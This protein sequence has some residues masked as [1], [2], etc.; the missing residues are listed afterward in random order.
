MRAAADNQLLTAALAYAAS[1][2]P[3]FPCSAADKTPLVKWRQAATTDEKQIRSWW[4]KHPDAM[5]GVPT[6]SPIGAFAID[7]DIGDV[8]SGPEFLAKFEQY[9][10]EIPPT[11]VVETG[12][13]GYHIYFA[14]DPDAPVHNGANIVPALHLNGTGGKGAQVDVRGEGGYVIVP[15]SV[16]TD[17]KRYSWCPGPEDGIAA[18]TERLKA[19]ALKKETRPDPEGDPPPLPPKPKID[20]DEATRRYALAALDDEARSIETAPNGSRNVTLN[21]AAF[22][23]GQLVGAG[24]LSE[25]V[26]RATLEDAATSCG[27]VREDGVKSVRDTIASGL[28]AGMTNP[29]DMARLLVGKGLK[30]KGGTRSAKK[31]DPETNWQNLLIRNRDGAPKCLLEN[32]MTVLKHHPE[33]RG[34]IGFDEFSLSTML[35]QPPPWDD[36]GEDL[37]RLP[38]QWTPQDDSL[39]TCWVQRQGLA[40]GFDVIQQAVETI[41]RQNGFHP[42]CNYLNGLKWDGTQRVETLFSHYLGAKATPFVAAVGRCFLVGA[43]ARAFHPG[44]KHDSLPILEG[45]QRIGKSTFASILGGSWFSDD[46]AELGSKDASLQMASAWIFELSELEAMGRAEATHIKAFISRSVDKFRPPYGRR[47]IEAPRQCVFIGTTNSDCYL[48]DETGGSRFWPVR[49]RKLNDADLRRDRDQLWAEA[50]QLY[51]EGAHW[52]LEDEDIIREAAEEQDARYEGDPWDDLISAYLAFRDVTSV[53]E[54][55]GDALHIEKGRWG[56]SEQMRVS[57]CLRHL[58]FD[59]QRSTV[60]GRRAWVYRRMVG[61]PEVVPKN[62]VFST[63]SVTP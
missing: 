3:V 50:V 29:R 47:V 59:R 61:E 2:W 32:A 30:A 19:I 36:G 5:I 24:A 14:T 44:C 45:Q 21:K 60:A 6:G 8:I 12:S 54:I 34:L 51:R 15:P 46:V 22:S 10:G 41:A 48:K 9:V 55:L 35:M 52:W 62:G 57:R 20:A 37:E 53:D 38:R 49:V 18:P 23:L 56:R 1:G 63:S 27:L 17:G 28:K 58:G 25:S 33:C 7:L 31:Q 40:A 39:L 4:K 43:V 11:A 26:V 13:G 42:L 16:R